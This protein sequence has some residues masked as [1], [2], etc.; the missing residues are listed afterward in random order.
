MSRKDT[1]GNQIWKGKKAA[2]KQ[3]RKDFEQ[4]P[5]ENLV[6]F[7]VA[8]YSFCKKEKFARE[9]CGLLPMLMAEAKRMCEWTSYEAG[10][11]HF[12]DRADAI[13]THL[14]WIARHT[15]LTKQERDEVR[16]FALRLCATGVSAVLPYDSATGHTRRL[17]TLTRARVHLEQGHRKLA[18]VFLRTELDDIH[19]VEDPR[20]RARVYAKAGLLCRKLGRHAVGL[21]LGLRA[22][23][24]PKVPLNVRGKGVVALAGLDL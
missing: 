21:S 8:L 15:S 7:A 19:L 1:I 20:Q 9:L 17:L 13:S 4:A 22:C 5:E 12:A 14:E 18:W 16:G 11:I 24:V 3:I 6:P 2:L 23:L 10:P